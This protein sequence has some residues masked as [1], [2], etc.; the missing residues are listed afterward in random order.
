MR[1]LF[2][3]AI[4]LGAAFSPLS[5]YAKVLAEGN[6]KNGFYWQKIEKS[7]GSISYLCRSTGSSKIQKHANCEDAGAQR[8]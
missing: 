5:S 4:V 6:V 3:A 8:P 7:N 1:K 2:V